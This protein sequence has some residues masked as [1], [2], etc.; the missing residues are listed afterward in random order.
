MQCDQLVLENSISLENFSRGQRRASYSAAIIV[1]TNHNVCSYVSHRGIALSTSALFRWRMTCSWGMQRLR[2][3]FGNPQKPAALV[4]SCRIIGSILA[5]NK[6]N[7]L[8]LPAGPCAPQWAPPLAKGLA[9]WSH[10]I[11]TRTH[12]EKGVFHLSSESPTAQT[13]VHWKRLLWIWFKIIQ[14]NWSLLTLSD[15]YVGAAIAI[16]SILLH[17]FEIFHYEVFWKCCIWV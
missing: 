3:S 2:Q 12:T 5:E 6:H 1:N 15:G 14:P 8:G 17:I 10:E 11:P 13:K 7:I 9:L 16:F 4:F